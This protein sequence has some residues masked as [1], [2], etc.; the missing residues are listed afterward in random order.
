MLKR[1][2]PEILPRPE[3]AN[4]SVKMAVAGEGRTARRQGLGGGR[5]LLF[6]TVPLLWIEGH[7]KDIK[8]LGTFW[9]NGDGDTFLDEGKPWI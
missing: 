2:Y 9:Q 5:G 1:G 7:G 6:H 8:V 4:A 3:R